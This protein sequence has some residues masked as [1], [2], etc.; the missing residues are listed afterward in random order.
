MRLLVVVLCVGFLTAPCAPRAE[1]KGAGDP[2]SVP[3]GRTF[4]VDPEKGDSKNDGSAQRPWRT[5][6][7]VLKARLVRTRDASGKLQNPNAP[8]GPGDTILLRSGYH[9]QIALAGAHNDRVIT[10]A[11]EK[12]H[13]PRL[14][15]LDV[16]DA[17][18]WTFRG[19]TISPSFA[20]KPYTRSMVLL[21]EGGPGSELI[22]ED[23]FLYSALDVAGWT[24]QDW[25]KRPAQGITLGRHGKKLTARNNHVLNTRFGIN[26][27]AP[28]SLC[29]GNIVENFSGDAIRVT[30]DDITVQYN[31]IKNVYVSD[32][33]G[34]KNHDDAIQC[35]LFNVG[36]GTV[37]RA[38]IRGNL[39]VNRE[40]PKQPF[41]NTLQAIGFF[42]GPLVDFV[43]EDNVINTS[44]WHGVSLYDAQGC[45]I[46][47]NT[48]YTEW[49]D[50]RLR[51]WIMLG[52]K[53]N[54]ARGNRV[55]NNFAYSFNFKADKDVVAENN[56]RVTK[57]AYQK[58][59]HALEVLLANKFGNTHP[60]SGRKRVDAQPDKPVVAPVSPGN[61]ESETPA[62]TPAPACSP[63]VLQQWQ[64]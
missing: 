5:L 48:V 28:D 39:I 55:L 21:A 34:D 63:E 42:D 53:K 44:H 4:H 10:V 62:Q 25:M 47:N 33:D 38:T 6:A 26:L 49:Q 14:G 61:A 54:Q 30:R 32:A 9:G 29:E 60:V 12:G 20:E 56:R 16:R 51:P 15:R 2:S 57:E 11:A 17:S 50:V 8:V 40:D 46:R 45:L 31:V 52:S 19:L 3:P 27:C 1:E 36:T 13:A 18:R 58:R 41:P 23:C 59:R 7:E 64:K 43:V 37:R 24:A 35:F 22:L